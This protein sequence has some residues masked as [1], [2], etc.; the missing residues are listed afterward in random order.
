MWVTKLLISPVK[1][2]TFCQKP[3]K[4]ARNWHFWSLWARPCPLIWCP[5]GGLAGGCGARAVSRKTPIYFINLI[6]YTNTI[7]YDLNQYDQYSD[8][9]KNTHICTYMRLRISEKQNCISEW[10]CIIQTKASTLIYTSWNIVMKEEIWKNE[11]FFAWW[12]PEPGQLSWKDFH[13]FNQ[14][15]YKVGLTGSEMCLKGWYMKCFYQICR[16]CL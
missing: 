11:L 9:E 2:S 15:K 10:N 1:I 8:L 5:V 4:L 16:F 14:T 13:K 6:W 12:W 3:P 7:L